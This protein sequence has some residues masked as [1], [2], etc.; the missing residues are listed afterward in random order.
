MI[1]LRSISNWL[2]IMDKPPSEDV[3]IIDWMGLDDVCAVMQEDAVPVQIGMDLFY[4]VLFNGSVGWVNAR[5]FKVL[6]TEQSE[7]DSRKCEGDM[8]TPIKQVIL[9]K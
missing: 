9:S 2:P 5:K 7:K 1:L 6:E 4:R 3:I 8:F